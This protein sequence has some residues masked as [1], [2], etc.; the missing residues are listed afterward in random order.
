L[1]IGTISLDVM[2]EGQIQELDAHNLYGLLQSYYTSQWFTDQQKRAFV[3]SRSTFSGSGKF[4][5][6]WL[7]ENDSEFDHMRYSLDNILLFS[8]FGIPFTGADICGF[9][10][11]ASDT[12]CTKWYKVATIYP[13]ARNHNNFGMM[14]Q[15]PYQDRFNDTVDFTYNKSSQQIMKKA[16]MMR[17]GLHNYV[18]TQFHKASTDGIPP[19]KPLFFGYPSDAFAYENTYND[20]LIGD[21]VKASPDTAAFGRSTYFFP[22]R[23]AQWCPIWQGVSNACIPG[24]SRIII[25]IP[26]SEIYLHFKS[27]HMIP[28][29][30]SNST[31]FEEITDIHSLED[32]KSYTTDIALLLNGNV[33]S[34]SVRFDDGETTD[35]DLYDEII[36]DALAVSRWFGGSELRVT[37]NTTR[38]E[39]VGAMT[40]SQ[41]LGDL[42]IYNANRLGLT[43]ARVGSL[44]DTSGNEYEI[45]IEYNTVTDVSRVSYNSTV[46]IPLKELVTLYFETS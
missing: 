37:F 15:E 3:M 24:D 14:E 12:L 9:N 1:E 13:F 33:A 16:M 22:E 4:G 27:G 19:I 25:E 11:N 36:F 23:N 31:A 30:L 29:Q 28:L 21:A 6:H 10:S 34:G 32:L 8:T 5:G 35:Y 20:I 26:L 42:L 44:L 39:S 38:T 46:A 2:H 45:S 41:K 18:Y 17:Y 40:N 43:R 7:G